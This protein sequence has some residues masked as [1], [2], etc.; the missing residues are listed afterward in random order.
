MCFQA[1]KKEFDLPSSLVYRCYFRGCHFEVIGY[2]DE[3]SVFLF[4][5]KSNPASLYFQS[6]VI[7]RVSKNDSLIIEYPIDC[8]LPGYFLFGYF[9]IEPGIVKAAHP[10]YPFLSP[11]IKLAEAPIA[12]VKDNN[13][14]FGKVDVFVNDFVIAVG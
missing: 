4:I 6:F 2:K 3:G 10:G 14:T 12:F 9:P 1:F 7:I 5:E 8:P 13:S 11:F